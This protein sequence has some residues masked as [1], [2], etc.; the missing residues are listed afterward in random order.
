[1]QTAQAKS[2]L[3]NQGAVLNGYF[4]ANDTYTNNY[5]V[6]FQWGTGNTYTADTTHQAMV[7]AGPFSQTVVGLAPNTL[8][9]VRAVAQKQGNGQMYY[10]QDMT[11]YNNGSNIIL[12]GGVYGSPTSTSTGLTNDFLTD[13]FFLPLIILLMGILM[14]R[15][16]FFTNIETSL[17]KKISMHGTIKTQRKLQAKIEEVKKTDRW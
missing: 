9:H 8:Y 16:G 3:N 7:N 15:L 5:M 12:T 6:W 17:R 4:Y 11:F 1:V 2:A 10:G 14:Y 13:S